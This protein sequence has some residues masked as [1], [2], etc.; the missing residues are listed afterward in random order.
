[1]R[2][3]PI[4]SPCLFLLSVVCL[5]SLAQAALSG[6]DV[7][8]S[9]QQVSELTEPAIETVVVTS[10]Y[11]E[12]LW[13]QAVG[14]V[15]VLDTR[16]QTPGM[17]Q[18][19][20][21][22]LA[23]FAGVQADSRSNFAQDT[24]LSIR[25][26]GARSAFGVRGISLRVDGVPLTMPDGQSQTS[27][28]LLDSID[29]VEVQRGPLASLYGNG[30]GGSI[31]FY[32]ASPEVSETSLSAAAGS[33]R[34]RRYQLQTSWVGEQ[35]AARVIA[36]TFS[37][38]GSRQHSSAEREQ[39]AAQWYYQGEEGL[40]VVARLDLSRDPLSQDPQGITYE[41]WQEDPSQVHLVATLFDPRKSSRHRQVSVSANKPHSWGR[42]QSSVWFGD[43]QVEQF[44]SFAGDAVDSGGAVI[45]LQ[46]QF[47]GGN[48][49]AERDFGAWQGLLGAE[50]G[51]MSDARRGFI[52]DYGLRG[53]LQRDEDN[54]VSNSD[55]FAGVTWSA[56]ERLRL[57]GGGRVSRV[58]FDVKDYYFTEGNPDDSGELT[59]TEPSYFAG[60]SYGEKHWR[61]FGNLGAGFG[62][63]TLTELAYRP[64]GSGF[65]QD[66]VPARNRQAEL[67]WRVQKPRWQSSLVAF[68]VR[69]RNELVVDQ[70]TGGRTT[71]RN[72]ADTERQGLEWMLDTELSSSVDW[73]LGAT[74]L[75]AEYTAGPYANHAIPGVARTNIYS[76]WEWQPLGDRLKIAVVGRFRSGVMTSDDND[77]RVPSAMTW[78]LA[79]TSPW[80]APRWRGEWW[81]KCSN[82]LDDDIVGSVIVN[83]S[84][85][86]TIEPA[87]GRQFSVGLTLTRR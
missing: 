19:S 1:M 55:L 47:A 17:G 29:R 61:L 9:E 74:W 58:S 40:I 5:P 82:L 27:S 48:A 65:N 72:G 60:V 80:E 54:T 69:T 36:R 50:L 71:Y 87:P 38:D 8:A 32:S 39:L 6:S 53:E 57:R 75:N 37:A 2:C 51:V 22:L 28:L 46:R 35:H 85:G 56:T 20:A 41:Q 67:G 79:L 24:R 77:E 11:S 21:E 66:L 18:D 44:L 12:G 15:A 43:R 33:A 13:Q 7:T 34:E 76:Q 68:M 10:G 30:A 45:D 26:F 62:A 49:I 4:H 84:R 52:N 63:P 70:S 3:S 25:G 73:R 16:R 86:R 78:D 81:V 64:E 23:G 83:Q 31:A 59:F 42:W 14:A